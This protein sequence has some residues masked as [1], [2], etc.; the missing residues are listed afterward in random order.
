VQRLVII[1]LVSRCHFSETLG[2]ISHA[3]IIINYA[4]VLIDQI[5]LDRARL[6]KRSGCLSFDFIRADGAKV[7]MAAFSV[8]EY[9]IVFEQV[10][11]GIPAFE[12]K[13]QFKSNLGEI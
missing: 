12:S 8:I 9:F 1:C 13:P 3:G 7:T 2:L 10:G 11:T 5:D 4:I 6:L